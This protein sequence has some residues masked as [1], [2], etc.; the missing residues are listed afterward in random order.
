MQRRQ[1]AN[2]ALIRDAVQG[3]EGLTVPVYPSHGNFM[4][5]DVTAAGISP[6]ALCGV[7]REDNVMIRQGGYHSDR[8]ADRFV[9]ISTSVPAEWIERLCELLPDVV[10]RARGVNAEMRAF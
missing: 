5:V 6:D 2:Q 1:R 4:I 9:K 8:F 7:L 3:I 10:A